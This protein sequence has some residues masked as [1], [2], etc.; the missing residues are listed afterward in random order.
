MGLRKPKVGGGGI[1][2][3]ALSNPA[4]AEQI[5]SGFEAIDGDGNKFAG[6]IPSQGA[7]TITPSTSN[8]TIASGLYL[9]GTQT[10]KGD[11]N[12]KAANILKGKSI[13]GVSGSAISTI[14][15]S[16]KVETSNTSYTVSAI[17][18][19]KNA[20]IIGYYNGVLTPNSATSNIMAVRITN[21]TAIGILD[22]ANNCN[23]NFSISYNSSTGALSA[24]SGCYFNQ[25][26]TYYYIAW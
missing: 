24:S 21:G 16:F 26:L 20:F 25:A 7:Q 8:Q 2:L 23:C 15:G 18:G 5:L 11:S 9:S 13:F 1:E 19:K 4:G 17:K 22:T 12:L 10:I 6:S 14:T 3:P